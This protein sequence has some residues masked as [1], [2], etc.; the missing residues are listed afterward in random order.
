MCFPQ[1]FQFFGRPGCFCSVFNLF[2][3]VCFVPFFVLCH[4]L[5]FVTALSELF[6][7]LV[8]IH[9]VFFTPLLLFLWQWVISILEIVML[10]LT[11][12]F[13]SITFIPNKVLTLILKANAAHGIKAI[14]GVSPNLVAIMYL[15]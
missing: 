7:R 9:L 8:T 2:S 13:S 1:F 12:V 6:F 10:C 11:T 3:I 4:F 5:F 15:K 14:N